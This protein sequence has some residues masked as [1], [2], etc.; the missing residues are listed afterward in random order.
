[1]QQR[2]TRVT[3]VEKTCPFWLGSIFTW[4]GLAKHYYYRVKRRKFVYCFR[5]VIVLTMIHPITIIASPIRTLYCIKHDVYVYG[6]MLC[7]YQAPLIISKISGT[8]CFTIIRY[9]TNTQGTE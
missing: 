7:S 2:A 3:D 5:R 1:M 8:G 4:I 6:S 9:D